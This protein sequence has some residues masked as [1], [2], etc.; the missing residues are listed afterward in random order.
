M[1]QDSGRD[2]EMS[3]AVA[4]PTDTV[5]TRCLCGLHYDP[6]GRLRLRLGQVE[7]MK[8]LAIECRHRRYHKIVNF[9][10]SGLLPAYR[11]TTGMHDVG[12]AVNPDSE[13]SPRS[14]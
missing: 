12:I 11:E 6:N 4:T 8:S 10:L 7:A 14:T 1:T 3:W 5:T 13:P 9:L 2:R